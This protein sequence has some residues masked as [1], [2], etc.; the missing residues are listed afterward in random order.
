MPQI[1]YV[2]SGA[3]DQDDNYPILI[4]VDADGM[5]WKL[6]VTTLGILT[7]EKII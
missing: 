1:Q 7:T 6:R 2:F 3:I 4:I 5:Q